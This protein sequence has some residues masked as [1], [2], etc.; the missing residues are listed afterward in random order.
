[1]SGEVSGEVSRVSVFASVAQS[2]IVPVAVVEDPDTAKPLA[3][4]IVAGGLRV[5]EVTLRTAAATDVLAQMTA[6]DDLLVGA[7]T[8]VRPGQVEDVVDAGA[9][10]VVTPGFSA[11]VVRECQALG[12]PVIPGIA[13]PTELQMA[14]DAGVDTVKFFPAAAAGG[15]PMIKA[16]TAPY[17]DVRFMPTGGITAENA[18]SFLAVPQVLAVGGSWM[19]A[20]DLLAQERFDEVTRLCSEAASLVRDAA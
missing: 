7:G 16:M 10:F 6:V 11:P 5:V 2:R 4:A 8:V 1:M 19:V 13:T 18:A 17:P 14:L 20:A 9:R 3:D 12:V 15:V